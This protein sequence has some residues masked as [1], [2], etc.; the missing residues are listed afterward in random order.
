MDEIFDPTEHSRLDSSPVFSRSARC[1]WTVWAISA[2]MDGMI[3]SAL[4]FS[5][6]CMAVLAAAQTSP[7]LPDAPAPNSAE[8]SIKTLPREF[9]HDQVGLWLSPLHM[10]DADFVK[11][12]LVLAAAGAIG[13]EDSGIM[14]RH[15]LDPSLNEHANTAST[16]LTG[17]FA[18]APAAFYGMGRIRKN[19]RAQETG[20]LAGEAIA[21][22]LAVNAVVKIASR[23][24]RPE[25][26]NARGYFF[27]SG[28]RYDSSFASNHSVIAW[29]SA[30]VI[31]SE[32]QNPLVG[33]VAYGMATGVSVTRVVGRDHFPSD[34]AI[35]SVLGWAIG[36]YVYRHRHRL[37]TLR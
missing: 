18:F 35:G 15:F 8:V 24:E 36:R 23:R 17:L 25:L 33:L 9:L 29:S 22:S 4:V 14:Q 10:N 2:T 7:S 11:T 26:D 28:V 30:A 20:I 32:Y 27:Q 6:L 21:D 16:G 12:L 31:A 3:R 37:R 5:M 13:S 19:E 1:C 34:V